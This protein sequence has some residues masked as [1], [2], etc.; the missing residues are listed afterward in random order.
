MKQNPKE[1][2]KMGQLLDRIE[3]LE[4]N[5]DRLYSILMKRADDLQLQVDELE[6]KLDKHIQEHKDTVHRY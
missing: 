6:E 4:E 3:K 2:I 5:F 1:K